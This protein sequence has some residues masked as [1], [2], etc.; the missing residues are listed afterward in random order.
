MKTKQ[1][2]EVFKSG[3]EERGKK[4]KNDRGEKKNQKNTE[5][6]FYLSK[7]QSLPLKKRKLIFWL[8]LSGTTF[9]LIILF[10]FMTAKRINSWNANNFKNQINL[11]SFDFKKLNEQ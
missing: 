4:E 10:I 6:K 3:G 5:P 1:K 11:P 9:L 2:K 8:I 7:I